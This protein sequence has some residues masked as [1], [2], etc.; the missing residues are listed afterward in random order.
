MMIINKDRIID[1]FQ[2]NIWNLECTIIIHNLYMNKMMNIYYYLQKLI[3][4]LMY[5]S[6]A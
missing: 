5:V 4:K 2:S 1:N 6:S 3:N